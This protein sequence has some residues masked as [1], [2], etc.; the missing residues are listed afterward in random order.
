MISFSSLGIIQLND[1]AITLG[2]HLNKRRINQFILNDDY[3]YVC[4]YLTEYMSKAYPEL[5]NTKE[6]NVLKFDLQ[7]NLIYKTGLLKLDKPVFGEHECE[8]SDLSIQNNQLYLGYSIGYE[9]WA[10]IETGKIIRGR[11]EGRK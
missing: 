3:I 2:K 7:G 4:T 5:R 8:V 9:A 1:K 10:D 11:F 6:N